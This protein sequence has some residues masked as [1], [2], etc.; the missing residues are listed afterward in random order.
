M[1]QL[2]FNKAALAKGGIAIF[3]AAAGTA[4]FVHVTA[5]S[6][7]KKYEGMV[8]NSNTG[9]ATEGYV[10]YAGTTERIQTVFEMAEQ[11]ENAH[12]LISGGHAD[13]TRQDIL[14]EFEPNMDPHL[15][16]F[17]NFAQNTRGNA[18]E[19]R[20]WAGNHALKSIT[21]VTNA[22]HAPRAYL[23]TTQVLPDN[24]KLHF[25]TVGEFPDEGSVERA[26]EAYKLWCVENSVC[27]AFLRSKPSIR[28][29]KFSDMP[30]D[31]SKETQPVAVVAN[32]LH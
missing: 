19:T 13:Y 23:E 10:A 11:Q 4:A 17:M 25:H 5:M 26:L 32:D 9:E 7:Y 20:L 14:D 1:D 6:Q 18:I 24:I 2:R 28:E 3:A 27:A 21:V 31:Q 12:V 29:P 15:V 22:S 8:R 30:E 16:E